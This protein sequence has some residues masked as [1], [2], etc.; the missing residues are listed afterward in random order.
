MEMSFFYIFFF[1]HFVI[2]QGSVVAHT[3]WRHNFRAMMRHRSL[4]PTLCTASLGIFLTDFISPHL[5]LH[6]LEI[7]CVILK[8]RQI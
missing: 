3:A 4:E 2:I 1:G 6:L 7:S 8:L 5:R